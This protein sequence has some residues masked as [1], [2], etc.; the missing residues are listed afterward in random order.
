V[1]NDTCLVLYRA[2]DGSSWQPFSR[3]EIPTQ[4]A[5]TK[6]ASPETFTFR[7]SSFISL[8]IEQDIPEPL[9]PAEIWLFGIED[10]PGNRIAIRCDDGLPGAVRRTDPE[11]YIGNNNVY[12][13]YNIVDAENGFRYELWRSKSG[14]AEYLDRSYDFYDLIDIAENWLQTGVTIPGD[15]YPYHGDGKVD[16]LDFAELADRWFY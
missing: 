15:I 9:Q 12:I 7:N 11:F 13:Y 8:Q 16:F 1:E 2:L 5:Y 10:H 4:S 14:L 6:I 3:L